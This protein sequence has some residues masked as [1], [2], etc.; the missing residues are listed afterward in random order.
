LPNLQGKSS[1]LLATPFAE[2]N[3]ENQLRVCA[4]F[5]INGLAVSDFR[6]FTGFRSTTKNAMREVPGK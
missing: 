2:K 5:K 6:N 4:W 3:R 1:S